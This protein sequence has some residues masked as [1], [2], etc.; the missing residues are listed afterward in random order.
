[1]ICIWS[2]AVLL[3]YFSFGYFSFLS[4]FILCPIHYIY[5]LSVYY[6]FYWIIALLWTRLFFMGGGGR[7]SGSCSQVTRISLLGLFGCEWGLPSQSRVA[8][9]GSQTRVALPALLSRHI[10]SPC[11]FFTPAYQ[12]TNPAKSHGWVFA[13]YF[14]SWRETWLLSTSGCTTYLTSV[15]CKLFQDQWPWMW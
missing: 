15:F 9:Q 3:W 8:S 12:A 1:M 10:N 6:C 11:G 7:N 4:F 2:T 5:F 14:H 13:L